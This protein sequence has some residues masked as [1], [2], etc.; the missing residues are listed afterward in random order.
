MPALPPQFFLSLVLLCCVVLFFWLYGLK[1]SWFPLLTGVAF[2]ALFVQICVIPHADLASWR[3]QT[4]LARVFEIPSLLVLADL[5][6][7][8]RDKSSWSSASLRSC[9]L[10]APAVLVAGWLGAFVLQMAWPVPAL[11][12]HAQHPAYSLHIELGRSIPLIAYSL[13]LSVLWYLQS[14]ETRS[15]RIRWQNIGL[16]VSMFCFFLLHVNAVAALGVATIPSAETRTSIGEAQDAFQNYVAVPLVLGLALFAALIVPHSAASNGLLTKP[17]VAF[18]R[19][20]DDLELRKWREAFS[21]DTRPPMKAMHYAGEAATLLSLEPAHRERSEKTIDF[22]S[23]LTG[24]VADASGADLPV[25]DRLVQLRARICADRKVNPLRRDSDAA[26][27]LDAVYAACLMTCR[28]VPPST[29]EPDITSSL[30]FNLAMVACRSL[31]ASDEGRP[32]LSVGDSQTYRR[33]EA[34]FDQAREHADNLKV[35]YDARTQS[36]HGGLDQLP[37]LYH[38]R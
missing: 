13:L 2:L 14:R 23:A 18:S 9:L 10:A 33:A 4:L 32:K 35:R 34:A 27:Y 11:D 29:S 26:I 15:S 20:R 30:W 8:Q 19:L 3:M 36:D 37:S 38:S 1:R 31:A 28:K 22:V 25:L 7:K 5:C 17:Y 16:A 21:Q 12:L 6:L 24:S